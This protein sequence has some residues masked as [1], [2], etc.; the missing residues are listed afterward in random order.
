MVLTDR[1]VVL[2]LASDRNLFVTATALD[3]LTTYSAYKVAMLMANLERM[4]YRTV[5]E[6]EVSDFME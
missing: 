3:R 2:A 1:K 4:G 5:T 6:T